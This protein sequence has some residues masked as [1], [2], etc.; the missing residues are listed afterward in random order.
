MS[1]GNL[2]SIGQ[3][4]DAVRYAYGRGKLIFSAAG[5][6]FSWANNIVGVIFPANMSETV[7]VTGVTDRNGYKECYNCHY[8]S[9]VDF[10]VVMQREGADDRTALTLPMSGN[11]PDRVGGSSVAT[12]TMA[13]IAGLVWSTNT[14]QSRSTVLQRLKESAEFYPNRNSN[15]GWGKIN[16]YNAVSRVQ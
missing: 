11:S 3:I 15:F 13:G 12:A 9:K 5:T 2:W 16:A 1:I 6:S 10:V 8:G 14:S 7:A 4:K